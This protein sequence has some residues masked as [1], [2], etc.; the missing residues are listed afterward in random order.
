M[1]FG[2]SSGSSSK[3]V[4]RW[5][6]DMILPGCEDPLNLGKS[7]SDQKLRKI[8]CVFS[9]CG[10][11]RW[12]WD[13]VYL[14]WG[15]PNIYSPSLSPPPWPLYLRTPAV[16]PKQCTWWPWS[17]ELSNSLGGRHRV[18]LKIHLEARIELTQG[19]TPRP[20]SSEFGDA[21]GDRDRANSEMH[22]IRKM[23]NGSEVITQ[24]LSFSE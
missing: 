20:W 2:R 11:M 10:K 12:K 15:R 6:E 8:E 3:S 5:W 19:Y 22:S 7:E 1:A 9:L 14:R 18:S 17:S 16:A 21:I 13:H 4:G 23:W 24:G